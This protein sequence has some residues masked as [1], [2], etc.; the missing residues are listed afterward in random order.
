MSHYFYH[1]SLMY[2]LFSIPTS[3]PAP[4][5][6]DTSNPQP[7]SS[8]HTSTPRLGHHV[9]KKGITSGVTSHIS[10]NIFPFISAESQ[11]VSNPPQPWANPLI[12]T[13]QFYPPGKIHLDA[14]NQ[15]LHDFRGGNPRF[16]RGTTKQDGDPLLLFL[17]WGIDTIKVLF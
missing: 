10:T 9:S 14:K 6:H 17:A 8:S 1:I 16:W 12:P 7:R 5:R 4:G 11:F 2:D 15:R 13:R 3:T